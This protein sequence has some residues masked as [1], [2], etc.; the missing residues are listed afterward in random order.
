MYARTT[1]AIGTRE[2]SRIE[3]AFCHHP[4]GV[5]PEDRTPAVILLDVFISYFLISV[6]R[7]GLKCIPIVP[8]QSTLPGNGV[9][10]FL[11]MTVFRVTIACAFS[12]FWEPS[13]PLIPPLS[14]LPACFTDY[15]EGE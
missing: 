11:C 10:T 6:Y 2:R 12:R 15:V 14:H 1:G 5:T 4:A 9:I 3:N 8:L 13:G 7:I